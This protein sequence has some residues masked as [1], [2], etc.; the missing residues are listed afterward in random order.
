MSILSNKQR[1]STTTKIPDNA[2][3]WR[4]FYDAVSGNNWSMEN[5]TRVGEGNQLTEV[6][7]NQVIRGRRL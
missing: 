2:I 6:K 3:S 5:K 1:N 4:D 7:C